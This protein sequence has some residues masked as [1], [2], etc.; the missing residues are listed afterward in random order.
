MVK[1]SVVIPCYN[2][3]RFLP[4]CLD[5]VLSQTLKEIEIIC[6]D[7][8]SSDNTLKILDSYKKKD[9]RITVLTQQNQY[10]GIARN[11]GIEKSIGK[12]LSFLD[13]DDFF[14]PQKLSKMYEKCEE[15]KADICISGGGTYNMLT[16]EVSHGYLQVKHYLL[17]KTIPFSAND[18]QKSIFSLCNPAPWNRLFRTGFIKEYGLKFQDVKQ[19]NDVFF[20]MSAMVLAKRITAIDQ[21]FVN[22]RTGTSTSLQESTNKNYRCFY[23]AYKKL[24]EFLVSQGLYDKYERSFL[25]QI[26]DNSRHTLNMTKTKEAWLEVAMFIKEK[27]IPEFGF[28]DHP[29]YRKNDLVFFLMTNTRRSLAKYEPVLRKDE[30]S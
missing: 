19:T 9:N 3:E 6:I 24:K 4:E 27:C 15:D 25:D 29:E 17:P 16:K 21:W 8:G 14:E 26:L 23:F 20:T 28:L 10:A 30:D 5:S 22:Y 18:T 13:S 12:Y 11:K 7:D 2:A 1:V